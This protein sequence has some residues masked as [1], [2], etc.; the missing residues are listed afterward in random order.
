M[1]EIK[2][3][4]QTVKAF[5]FDVDGVFTNG[6]VLLHPGGE[7]IRMMN[8]K[9]GFAV[10]HAVK[11]GYPIA[12]ITGG[13]S[14]MIRKRFAYLGVKDI[15]MKSANKLVAYNRF[16]AAYGLKPENIL[17][18]GDDLP[19]CEVMIKSGYPNCPSDAA[20]E[21]KELAA[22]ISPRKGGEGCVRDVIEQ[23]LRLHGKWMNDN[24]FLW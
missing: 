13:Y 15:Y 22:Y 18:M 24:T 10:Q 16:L 7:F 8:I 11:M 5:V 17:Y 14:R 20:E 2:R 9:D 6:T 12:I 1:P 3:Q 4:L 23:V 21:I 19:D